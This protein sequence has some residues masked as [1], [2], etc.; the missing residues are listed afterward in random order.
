MKGCVC[1]NRK[2]GVGHLRVCSILSLVVL[3]IICQNFSSIGSV[4]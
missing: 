4:L 1:M 3:T 2:G